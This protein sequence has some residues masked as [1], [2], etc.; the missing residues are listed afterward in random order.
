MRQHLQNGFLH[1]SLG[2]LQL[3]VFHTQ[4]GPVL[5]GHG[6]Q[7]GGI[8]GDHGQGFPHHSL[9]FVLGVGRQI[10]QCIEMNAALG[11][12]LLQIAHVVA[13]LQ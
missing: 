13:N 3:T 8:R 5:Q 1:L 4:F 6:L 10:Q 7:P 9:K 2:Y 12:L 11:Q